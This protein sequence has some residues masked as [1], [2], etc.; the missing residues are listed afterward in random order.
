[1]AFCDETPLVFGAGGCGAVGVDVLPPDGC[2]LRLLDDDE[3]GSPH[4][5]GPRY[6]LCAGLV[7]APAVYAREPHPGCGDCRG[8]DAVPLFKEAS[9]TRTLRVI[10]QETADRILQKY[11]YG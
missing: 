10:F 3:R 8:A 4:P 6:A 1:M 11:R 5:D 2:T 9:G 7:A